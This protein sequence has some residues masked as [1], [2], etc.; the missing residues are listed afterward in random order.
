MRNITIFDQSGLNVSTASGNTTAFDVSPYEGAAFF[1]NL[2]ALTGGTS[3]T[4]QFTYQEMDDYGVW[5]DVS[6][7]GAALSAAGTARTSVGEGC[8]VNDM[9]GKS[10]RIK[11]VTTGAPATATATI[12][13]LVN[14]AD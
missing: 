12:S 3:P 1:V 2:T 6:A 4:V 7:I 10:G 5:Y 9:I 13:V 8:K 14:E 11:W